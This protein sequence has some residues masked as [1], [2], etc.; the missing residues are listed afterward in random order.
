MCSNTS[1]SVQQ[2]IKTHEGLEPD[3][4][5]G[6]AWLGLALVTRSILGHTYVTVLIIRNERHN[7]T[8]LYFSSFYVLSASNTGMPVSRTS[9]ADVCKKNSIIKRKKIA[10]SV[11]VMSITA[12]PIFFGQSKVPRPIV[13]PR[14]G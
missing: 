11:I 14:R 2:C 7:T 9:T 6:L 13:L 1:K 10:A 4:M 5:P 8:L 3:W 12:L